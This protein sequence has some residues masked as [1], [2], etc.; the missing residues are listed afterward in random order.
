MELQKQFHYNKKWNRLIACILYPVILELIFHWIV[1]PRSS[2]SVV[3]LAY[4]AAFIGLCLY[5]V[6]GLFPSVVNRVLRS[7]ERRVG[8]DCR[9]SCRS[10]W[11]PY[12]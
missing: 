1:F 12:H 6:T 10:R 11:S 4:F 7:E 8:K 5:F 2:D 9:C 3:Y